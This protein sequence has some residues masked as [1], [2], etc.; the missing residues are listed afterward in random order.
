MAR[1]APE[2]SH[3]GLVAAGGRFCPGVHRP[4][5]TPVPPGGRFSVGHAFQVE[6]VGPRVEED[7]VARQPVASGPADLLVVALDRL[8]HIPMDDEAD[9]GLVD[10]HAE[11]NG[12]G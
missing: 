3:D 6:D 11:G 1:C 2:P 7:A 8:R 10:S 9:V 12:G 5:L 4:H